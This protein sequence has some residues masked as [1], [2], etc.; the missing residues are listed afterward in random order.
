MKIFFISL[1]DNHENL[2]HKTF[3]LMDLI[4]YV[5]RFNVSNIKE[6]EEIEILRKN[7]DLSINKINSSLD[8]FRIHFKIL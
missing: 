2:K 7:Y 4:Y 6:I 5:S 1:R 8:Y 3:K